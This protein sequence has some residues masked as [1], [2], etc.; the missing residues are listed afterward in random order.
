MQRNTGAN[1]EG[2]EV[3]QRNTGANAEGAE[4]TQRT[5]KNTKKIPKMGFGWVEGLALRHILA[6]IHAPS[7][8]IKSPAAPNSPPVEGYAAGGGGGGGGVNKACVSGQTTP[9]GFACHPSNGGEFLCSNAGAGTQRLRRR[10]R[11]IPK[12][13]G[14]G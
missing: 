13:V 2:A 8:P 14:L 1:A 5:Q 9:S 10:R 7:L 4:V 11:K 6:S 12:R 3:T